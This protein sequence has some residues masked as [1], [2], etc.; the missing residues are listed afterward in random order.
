MNRDERWLVISSLTKR[1]L[2]WLLGS[3]I[4]AVAVG[5]IIE[6][7]PFAKI[8][9]GGEVAV[10]NGVILGVLLGLRNRA[11][12][13]R[14]WEARRLWGQL[15]NDSRNLAWKVR[16]YLPAQ[17]IAV[18]HFPQLL[19]GFAEAL[20]N[21]LRGGGRLQQIAGFENDPDQPVHVPSYLA[22][23]VIG[24]IAQWQRDDLIDPRT[25]QVLDVPSR[26]LLD[27]C[28]SCERIRNTPVSSSYRTLLRLGLTMNVLLTPWY[29]ILDFG[30]WCIPILLTF[31]FFVIGLEIV[32]TA[33]EEPFGTEIDDLPLERYCRTIQE[34]MNEILADLPGAASS[35]GSAGPTVS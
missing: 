28:G 9:W 21:H 7:F 18:A 1:L 11:A 16:S 8:G 23:H 34:S 4:Y 14:W 2:P 27:I 25:M 12:Y 33:V 19:A 17:A 32:D 31:I 24:C 29:T 30:L 5:E 26:S 15:V 22:G 13:D 6:H 10:A 20:K 3:T 35:A